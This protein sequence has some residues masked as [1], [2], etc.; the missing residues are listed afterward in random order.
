[1]VEVWTDQC[2]RSGGRP[3]GII[4]W[5]RACV[6]RICVSSVPSRLV[7][8]T[9]AP[10][11]C[12]WYVYSLIAMVHQYTTYCWHRHTFAMGTS[13][14]AVVS[15]HFHIST[16]CTCSISHRCANCADQKFWTQA[17]TFSKHTGGG[18]L[19]IEFSQPQSEKKCQ[20]IEQTG[21]NLQIFLSHLHK[22]CSWIVISRTGWLSWMLF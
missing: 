6:L 1:M 15:S 11:I 9:H 12:S 13:S 20:L 22:L 10:H 7:S 5:R 4:G 2:R 14:W 18:Y 16:K 8:W 21:I 17:W 19:Q 3:M